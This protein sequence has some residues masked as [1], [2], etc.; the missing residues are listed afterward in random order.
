M[1]NYAKLTPEGTRDYLFEESDAR[2]TVERRLSDLFK[3]HG[4]RRIITPTYEFFDVFNRESAGALPEAMYS[5]TD[6]Y[7]RLLV[8]RPDST[9]PI[10]RVAATRLQGASLP[11]R[12]YYDQNVFTRQ[13]RLRDTVTN[14]RK[15]V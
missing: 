2:R 8:L 6:A 11:I 3:A 13:P 15:A 5:M 7:G 9:L 4:Y 14:V 1:K 12:L 10:A